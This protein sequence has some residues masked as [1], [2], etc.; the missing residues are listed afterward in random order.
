MPG[1]YKITGC[2]SATIRTCYH[3]FTVNWVIRSVYKKYFMS[4]DYENNVFAQFKCILFYYKK[5]DFIVVW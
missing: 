5:I 4:V 3:C 1:V 2:D